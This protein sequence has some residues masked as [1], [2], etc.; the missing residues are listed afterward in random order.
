MNRR[1]LIIFGAVCFCNLGFSRGY[2]GPLYPEYL[3]GDENYVICDGH[4][5]TAWYVDKNSV[6]V[7]E[8]TDEDVPL[9]FGAGHPF[10]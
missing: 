5:G 3:Y 7:E 1:L 10:L 9:P 4:M 8:E 2:A 6:A